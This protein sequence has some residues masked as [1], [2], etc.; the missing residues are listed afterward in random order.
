MAFALRSPFHCYAEIPDPC[1]LAL[2]EFD[3]FYKFV[4]SL[5][6]Y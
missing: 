3:F 2:L 1:A 5:L 4:G 6:E